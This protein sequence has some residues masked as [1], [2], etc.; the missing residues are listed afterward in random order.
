MLLVDGY[1]NHII[2]SGSIT[3]DLFV[4]FVEERVLPHCTLYLKL[5]SVLILNNA[6]IHKD[7][8]LH[9]LCNN[10]SVVLKFLLLYSL[11]YNPIKATFKDLKA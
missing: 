2:Y 10:A 6:L 7:L 3:A 9:Q 5:H 4:E 8:R 11:D 1:L